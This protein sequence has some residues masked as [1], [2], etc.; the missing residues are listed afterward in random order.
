MVVLGHP[1]YYPKFGF[2][3]ASK[4]NI[5]PSIKVPDEAFMAIELVDGWLN[6]KAGLIEYPAEYYQAL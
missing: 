1:E 4:W 3:R 5:K 6:D 2:N